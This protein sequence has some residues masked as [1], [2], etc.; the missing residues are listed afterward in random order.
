MCDL[1]TLHL[2]VG[3]DH[4]RSHARK[5]SYYVVIMDERVVKASHVLLCRWISMSRRQTHGWDHGWN[6]TRYS[7][8][9]VSK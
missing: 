5:S 4:H 7:E 1:Y 8:S 3:K 9:S 6:I 2:I